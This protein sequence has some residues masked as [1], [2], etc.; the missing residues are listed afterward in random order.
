M[1]LFDFDLEFGFGFVTIWYL[2]IGVFNSRC[3]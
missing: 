2:L 3:S 1:L